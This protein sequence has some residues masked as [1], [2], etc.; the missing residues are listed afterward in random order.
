MSLGNADITL[1]HKEYDKAAR[2]D[3]WTANVYH[4]VHWHGKRAATVADNGLKA[5]STYTVRIFGAAAVLAAPGDVIVRGD[6]AALTLQQAK[7]T[8]AEHIKVLS[9]TDNRRG[10]LAVQHWRL[11]GE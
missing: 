9:V 3:V 5:G 1:Y 10:S 6:T 11:E 4:N 8:G 2:M 7:D